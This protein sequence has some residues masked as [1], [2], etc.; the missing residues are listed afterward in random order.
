MMQMRTALAQLVHK[1]K[2]EPSV[3][4]DVKS[5]PYSVILA[6]ADGGSVKFVPR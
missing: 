3:P 5:D 6:P 4:Y 1:Y 2:L